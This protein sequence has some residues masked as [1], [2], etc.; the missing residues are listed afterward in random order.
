M[1]SNWGVQD[2]TSTF[3][4][5][6]EGQGHNVYVENRLPSSASNPYLVM[7]GTIAAGLDGITKQVRPN[8]K[9]TMF[10]FHPNISKVKCQL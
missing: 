4:L 6:V 7:A 5:K 2:R 10:M 8:I 1:W 9:S 3:R